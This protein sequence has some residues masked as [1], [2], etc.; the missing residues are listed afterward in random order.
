[1]KIIT[2]FAEH[3]LQCGDC[4]IVDSFNDSISEVTVFWSK[5]YECYLQKV[6]NDSVTWYIYNP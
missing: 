5:N 4:T 3:V 1:M 2:K 6:D